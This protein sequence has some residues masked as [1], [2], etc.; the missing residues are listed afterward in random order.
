MGLGKTFQ[1][2]AVASYYKDDWP[3]LI[4]TTSS[5]KNTWEETIA[6]YMPSI[7]LLY[8]QYMSTVKDFIN[9][10]KV[11]ITSYDMMGR[12]VDRLLKRNF[13]FLILV[14]KFNAI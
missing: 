14:S 8:I 4:I 12:C 1:A 5:M 11:L 7:P 9:D 13:K 6:K 3:L 10:A 2:L